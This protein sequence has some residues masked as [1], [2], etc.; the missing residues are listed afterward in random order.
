MQESTQVEETKS[1]KT[2]LHKTIIFIR[3]LIPTN[4][5]FDSMSNIFKRELT[6]AQEK[7]N[8]YPLPLLKYL[9]S[10]NFPKYYLDY[11]FDNLDDD[12]ENNSIQI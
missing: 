3:P 11:N 10:K 7:F 8:N 5:W 12:S 4:D 9:V 2:I 6:N 1:P